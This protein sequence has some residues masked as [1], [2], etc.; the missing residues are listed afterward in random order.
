MID[1][2]PKFDE[3]YFKEYSRRQR[4]L[5]N[6]KVE[7]SKAVPV[8]GCEYSQTREDLTML[9]DCALSR[10]QCGEQ[11][12]RHNYQKCDLRKRALCEKQE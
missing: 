4:A 11:G 10:M 5:G 7:A 8:E 6:E 2:S 1:T 3:D 12:W 9:R